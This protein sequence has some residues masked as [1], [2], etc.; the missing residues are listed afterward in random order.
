MVGKKVRITTPGGEFID[1]GI[2]KSMGQGSVTIQRQDGTEVIYRTASI[3]LVIIDLVTALVSA[4]KD[5][6]GIFRKRRP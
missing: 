2:V 1:Q 3:V 5:L 4:L 6:V